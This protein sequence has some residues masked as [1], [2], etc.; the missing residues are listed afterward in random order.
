[1]RED[2]RNEAAAPENCCRRYSELK[3]GEA[4]GS[5]T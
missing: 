3:S 4:L 1:V 2:V 5:D